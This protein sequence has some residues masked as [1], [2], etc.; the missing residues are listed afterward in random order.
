MQE[1][2]VE[3]FEGVLLHVLALVAGAAGAALAHFGG[4]G[5][6]GDIG[7]GALHLV[8]DA[9]FGGDNIFG[10]TVLL[11]VLE[12]DGGGAGYVGHGQH[13][14]FAFEVGHDEGTGMLAAHLGD[15]F[16]RET[17][18]YVAAALPE[19]HVAAGGGIDVRPEVVV[20]TEDEFLVGRETAYYALGIA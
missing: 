1:G 10:R 12:H 6:E 4:Y 18:V 2:V 14:T 20:G 11:G 5:V 9:G 3:F 17:L 7:T 19:E 13:G 15:G 16:Y 8:K